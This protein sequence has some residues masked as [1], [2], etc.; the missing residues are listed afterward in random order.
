[1]QRGVGVHGVWLSTDRAD[2]IFCEQQT[3]PAHRTHII[4][5]EICHLLLEHGSREVE[6]DALSA[7]FPDLDAR[8]VRRLLL[9]SSYNSREEQEAEFLASLIL[10]HAIPTPHGLDDEQDRADVSMALL[11]GGL[12]ASLARGC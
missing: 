1:M 11:A 6:S 12:S 7:L 9:R 5:H 4:I 8:L 10:E 2:Y 3:T